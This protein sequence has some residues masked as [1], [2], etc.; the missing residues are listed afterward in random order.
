MLNGFVYSDCLSHPMSL[1]DHVSPHQSS[2]THSVTSS[3]NISPNC[4]DVLLNFTLNCVHFTLKYVSF[5]H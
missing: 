2:P 3:V 4:A 5:Y 1:I